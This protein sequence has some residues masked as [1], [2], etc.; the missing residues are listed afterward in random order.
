MY[1]VLSPGYA[2]FLIFLEI[3]IQTHKFSV[4]KPVLLSTRCISAQVY[5]LTRIDFF[6]NRSF[7][8]VK[9]KK[10]GLTSTPV[11]KIDLVATDAHLIS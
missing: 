3:I 5:V 7:C 4:L 2:Y 8:V 6:L 10:K 1:L 11:I 9:K